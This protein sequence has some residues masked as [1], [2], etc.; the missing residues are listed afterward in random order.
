MSMGDHKDTNLYADILSSKRACR[1]LDDLL[2][3]RLFA[4][5][6]QEWA[7]KA[8][9][10]RTWISLESTIDPSVDLQ[11]LEGLLACFVSSMGCALNASAT[12]A[13]QTVKR[14]EIFETTAS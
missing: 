11:A 6:Q 10:T 14:L 8:L 12:H 3:L 5:R 7:E 1:A 9:V 13:I 4:D 2:T